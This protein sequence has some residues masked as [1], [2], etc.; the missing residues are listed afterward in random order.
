MILYLKDPET[1]AEKLLDITNN[2]SKVVDTKS[3]Y[4]TQ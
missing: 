1:S 2:F 4:K 3:I